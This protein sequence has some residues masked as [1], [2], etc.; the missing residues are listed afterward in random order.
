MKESKVKTIGVLTS[1]GD[2][3]GMNAAIRA[4]VRTALANGVQV[5]GIY[6]GFE[7]LMNNDMV[8]MD[9]RN[10]SNILERGGTMLYSARSKEFNS[11][12]GVA[13]AVQICVQSGIEGLV[14]CGGDG[15]FRGARDLSL[16]G[17]HC[18]GVPCTIDNDIAC[19][20]FTIGFDTA[21]L[22][23][24]ENIDRL[25]DT[26]QAHSRCSV[27][28]VMGRHCG[29]IALHAGVACGAVSVLVPPPK[30]D[31][32]NKEPKKDPEEGKK[33]ANKVIERIKY[34]LSIGKK[35][36]IVIV[37]E[38]VTKY[39]SISAEE[40]A[41]II[42]RE[43]CVESRETVLGHI[44]RGGSPSPRDRILA[45]QMGNYAVNLIMEGKSNRVVAERN[46]K[47]VDFDILKGLEMKRKFNKKLYNLSNEISI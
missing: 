42:E 35:H 25:R 29:D 14:V 33:I 36:F 47:I 6:S 46:G 16:R 38:G 18:I 23:V 21:L 10:V 1:G 15:S 3:P 22:T 4:V 11:P 17:I 34:S 20:D 26:A 28:E 44:Q 8:D 31:S 32:N 45:S 27:V 19:T 13:K 41:K 12:E 40:L 30:E 37:A 5:K 39:G 24:M 9:L 7:G 43:T 2:A